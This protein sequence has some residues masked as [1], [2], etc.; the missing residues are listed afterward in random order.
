MKPVVLSQKEIQS[1]RKFGNLISKTS[2]KYGKNIAL[3]LKIM[4]SLPAIVLVISDFLIITLRP[5]HDS[6]TYVIIF[7]VLI[8]LHCL[9]IPPVLFL[10]FG[11]REISIYEK[12]IGIPI[13]TDFVAWIDN[14]KDEKIIPYESMINI[15][16][17]TLNTN[18]VSKIQKLVLSYLGKRPNSKGYYKFSVSEWEEVYSL[19]EPYINDLD[20]APLLK[21][22]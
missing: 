15:E 17:K 3:F 11:Y 8:L 10:D 18:G 1:K 9:F 13:P 2:F 7:L 12:G 5:S 14:R 20:N 6:G 19:I 22:E 16:K 4:A 21:I